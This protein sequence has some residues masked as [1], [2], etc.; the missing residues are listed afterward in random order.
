MTQTA[1]T[2]PLT[3]DEAAVRAALPSL[4]VL[5]TLRRMFASLAAARAVQPPQTLTLFPNQAGD[6]I[7]YLGALADAQVFGAKLSPYVVTGGKPIVTAWTALMSMQTG[8][9]LMWCDAGLLTVERTAGTTALAVDCLAARDARHLAIVGAGAVGLAHL[10]HTAALRDW[11]TI[12]V[13]SPALAGDAAQQATL[14]ELD[15]R[16]RA[17]AS[18]EACV[19]DSDVVML[20]TSSGAPV[21]GDGML[22]RPALV[23]SI[24]TNVARAHEIPPAWLPDM[25]VYCDYRHTTP[26]SA[27]EMQIAAADHGWEAGRIVGDLPALVAGTCAAPSRTRHAFFRSIGLGLEDIAIAHALYSHLTRA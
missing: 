16:A 15:P 21:L 18:V 24:S 23:T 4:D 1:P 22:T 19:R 6:F 2:L 17:A 11:D 26:A 13:Y 27:G 9:P 3:V 20:C 5:G 25:D 10:R 12:R 14:A 8:Q 7:T